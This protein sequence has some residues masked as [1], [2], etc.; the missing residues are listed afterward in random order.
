MLR[1]GPAIAMAMVSVVSVA[2]AIQSADAR[3]LNPPQPQYRRQIL[4]N[5]R[6]P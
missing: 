4:R 6:P 5:P 1:L 3:P 2:A